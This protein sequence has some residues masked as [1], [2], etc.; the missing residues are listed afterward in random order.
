MAEEDPVKHDATRSEMPVSGLA[1]G[2]APSSVPTEHNFQVLYCVDI[3]G[4]E[5]PEP[6]RAGPA[7]Y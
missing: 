6:G 4:K 3:Y 2:I 1:P 5:K 7:L